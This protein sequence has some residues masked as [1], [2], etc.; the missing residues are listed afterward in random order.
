MGRARHIILEAS[1]LRDVFG[2]LL[3]FAIRT[4]VVLLAVD[5]GRR[6]GKE[7]D[8]GSGLVSRRRVWI[9]PQIEVGAGGLATIGR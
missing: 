9:G 5:H 8:V 4:P 2:V 6:F 7:V 1:G 3:A